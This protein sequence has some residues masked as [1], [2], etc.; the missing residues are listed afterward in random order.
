MNQHAAEWTYIHDHAKRNAFFGEV[1]H[2]LTSSGDREVELV[3]MPDP[4]FGVEFK[5]AAL[6]I[7]GSKSM[8]Q[9]F[10][11]HLPPL[12]R[13][14]RNEVHPTA[15]D[16]ALHL[17]KNSG[18][19]CAVAY[20]A[21]GDD[22][23]DVEPVG[24]MTSEELSSFQFVGPQNWGG[25]TKLTPIVR[26]FWEQVFATAEGI[27]LAVILTDG[28]WDDDDHRQLMELT[29]LMCDE[30][31]AGRRPLMK[32]V[33]LGLKTNV[34]VHET[35]K[36]ESRFNSLDDFDSG[37]EIDVWDHKWVH[38]MSDWNEIFIELVK[39]WPLGIGGRIVDAAGSQLAARD[40][41]NFGIHFQMP[42]NSREFT[43][44]LDDVGEFKQ[45]VV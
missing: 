35:E 11:A 43:L 20:W 34:N 40:E 23:G 19:K 1:K 15:L 4:K 14:K 8:M 42:G 28:A 3:V 26:Y 39:D 44:A 29:Q 16:I 24:M 32:S 2:R 5:M 13:K 12:A 33:I 21:C 17:A 7:D 37:T 10:A 9:P 6:A 18:G 25:G 30:T 22:G 27:G 41:F 36:I 45:S 31:A 38:E